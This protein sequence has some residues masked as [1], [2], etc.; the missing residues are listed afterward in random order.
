M[1]HWAKETY[2]IEFPIFE[3]VM[4]NGGST[5]PIF[6]DL[7]KKVGLANCKWN[8]EKFLV[9]PAGEVIMHGNSKELKPLGMEE[10]IKKAIKK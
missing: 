1:A 6:K 5:H 4:V 3:K 8:F 9:D 7:K 2:K 10:A